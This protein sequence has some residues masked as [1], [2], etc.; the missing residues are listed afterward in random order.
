[1]RKTK[2]LRA[3][4][5]LQVMRENIKTGIKKRSTDD[6][7]E[8][9]RYKRCTNLNIKKKSKR[10]LIYQQRPKKANINSKIIRSRLA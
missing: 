1:M 3:F 7:A 10:I 2:L 4:K 9:Y 8:D 6:D 5:S